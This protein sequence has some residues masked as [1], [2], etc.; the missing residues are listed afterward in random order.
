MADNEENK[1]GDNAEQEEEGPNGCIVCLNITWEGL[2]S[3]WAAVS[4]VFM[5]ICEGIGYCWYPTKE[6][7]GECCASCHRCCN[8]HEDEAFS[9]FE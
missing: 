3:F 2:K 6:R 4:F 8:E 5:K 9:G 1:D 7:C